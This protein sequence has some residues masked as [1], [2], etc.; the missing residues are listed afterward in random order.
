MKTGIILSILFI[1]VML[2]DAVFGAFAEFSAKQ[3]ALLPWQVIAEK[4]REGDW[5]CSDGI[6]PDNNTQR[7]KILQI[8][9]VD[10]NS[11]YACLPAQPVIIRLPGGIVDF[12]SLKKIKVSIAEFVENSWWDIGKAITSSESDEISFA[13]GI[14]KEGFFRLSFAIVTQDEQKHHHEAYAVVSSNWKKDILAFCR[15]LK[16][17]IELNQDA[18]LIRSSIAVSHFDHI[19]EMASEVSSLSNGI[20]KALADALRSKK[21]FDSGQYPDLVIGLNKIRL[22]RFEGAPIEEFVVF[23]PENYTSSKTWPVLLNTDNRRLGAKGRYLDRSGLI[24]IWWHTVSHKDLKWKNYT[25]FMEVIKQKVNIDKDRIY[26]YG[27]CSNGIAAI[28]LALNYPDQWAECSSSLGNSY[29]H[30]A[31]NALN[32]PIILVRGDIGPDGDS[33]I[34]YYEFAVKCFQYYGSVYFK[35]SQTQNVIRARGAR[36]PETVRIKKP[37]R[38]LYTIESLGNPKSYW[39][40]IKS[41]DDENLPGTIDASVQGRKVLI[42]TKNIDSYTLNLDQAPLDINQPVEIIENGHSIGFVTDQIFTKKAEKFNDITIAKN[43]YLHGPVWDAFTDPYVV[44]WGNSSKDKQSLKASEKVAR[45]LANGGLCFADNEMQEELINSHNLVLVSTVESNLWFS[46]IYKQLPVQIERGQIIAG[47][48]RY[49]G[50]DIGFIL[51]YPNPM[52]IQKYVAV[53]FG[54]SIKAI[55]KMPDAYSQMRSIRPIDVGIFEVTDS[56]S[57]KWHIFEKFN[58]LWDWHDDWNRVLTQMN[59][60]HPKWKWNQWIAKIVREQLETDIAICESPFLFE[61]SELAGQVTY[62]DLFNAFRNDWIVKIKLDGNN[63]RKLLTVPFADISKREVKSLIISGVS[64]GKKKQDSSGSILVMSDLKDEQIY[65]IAI[66]EKLINGQRTGVVLKD[67]K[68]VG[69]YYLIPLLKDYLY[70]GKNLDIDT[71]LDKLKLNMF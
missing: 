7:V 55:S 53:F 27:E 33:L 48:K 23:I 24:D 63:L 62:R 68:I 65:T 44:V 37:Q 14:G 38:V 59:R 58:T 60:K 9:S 51:I 49:E 22:K 1:G 35:N 67:Y 40:K 34:G 20:L 46:R 50:R 41:R 32:L 70:K 3:D 71:E 30:L 12:S 18:Q 52:N 56:D 61:D 26:I 31:G 45:S 43:E 54:T 57:I 42:E 5:F 4:F 47:G 19:M 21:A 36:L 11:S 10:P 17:E 13:S 2:S 66:P 6:L 64:Y 39:I 15:V 29:R 25:A 16:E 28:A 69:D 8:G